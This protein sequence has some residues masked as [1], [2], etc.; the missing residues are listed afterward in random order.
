MDR[1]FA[2]RQHESPSNKAKREKNDAENRKFLL[3]APDAFT[4]R[5]E[6]VEQVSGQPVWVISGEPKPGFRTKGSGPDAQIL[7]KV[8]GKVWIDQAEYRWVKVELEVLETLSLDLSL[9]RIAPGT[10]LTSEQARVNDEVWLPSHTSI[11]G[12]VRMGYLVKARL[13][14]EITYR[15]YKKFQSDSRIVP[16]GERK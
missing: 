6:G 12:D 5:L 1:E 8:R 9:V 16:D 2:R 10:H 7:T 11:R 14:Q 15:D 4:L 13:E 3:Q